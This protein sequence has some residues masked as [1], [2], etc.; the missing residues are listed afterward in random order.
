MKVRRNSDEMAAPVAK[1]KDSDSF[2]FDHNVEDNFFVTTGKLLPPWSFKHFS[3]D[4]SEKV[5]GLVRREEK[6][7]EVKNNEHLLQTSSER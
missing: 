3:D 6:D 4:V 1:I 7:S 2:V 5:Y